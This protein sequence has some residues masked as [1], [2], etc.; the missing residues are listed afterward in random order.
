MTR[1]ICWLQLIHAWSRAP[2]A[3]SWLVF[4]LRSVIIG[5]SVR[6]GIRD[7]YDLL[8]LGRDQPLRDIQAALARQC[9]GWGFRAAR[10]GRVAEQARE[11]LALIESASEVFISAE[12]RSRYDADLARCLPMADGPHSLVVDWIALAWGYFF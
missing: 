6:F 7:F 10:S 3:A 5:L 4:L 2:W 9:A 1:H 8:G 12:S 11:E